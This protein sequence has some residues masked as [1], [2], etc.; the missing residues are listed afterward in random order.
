MAP[1]CSY[2]HLCNCGILHARYGF[3]TWCERA[4]NV[5]LAVN[6]LGKIIRS[7]QAFGRELSRQ[8][9]PILPVLGFPPLA[10]RWAEVLPAAS[11]TLEF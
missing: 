5:G 11:R 1:L 2:K 4:G 3:S 7:V 10:S 9:A 8:A 6:S